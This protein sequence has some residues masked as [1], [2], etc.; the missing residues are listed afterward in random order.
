MALLYHDLIARRQCRKIEFG[1]AIWKRVGSIGGPNGSRTRVT[2]LRT[3]CPG[4]LDDGTQN[5]LCGFGWVFLNLPYL[6]LFLN[7]R[8]EFG[9]S[10]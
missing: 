7:G 5:H 8:G 4:P 10:Q 9:S 3:R 1:M 2:G 6:P